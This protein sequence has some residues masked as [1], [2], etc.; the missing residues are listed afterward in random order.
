VFFYAAQTTES[1]LEMRLP[2][3]HPERQHYGLFGFMI[4]QGL[5]AGVPMTYR[6]LAQ[7]VLNQYGAMNQARHV[8]PLFSGTNLDA[9]VFGQ[10]TLPLQQ[11]KIDKGG[12]ATISAGALSRLDDGALFAIVASPLDDVK[13]ALGYAEARGV[14]LAAS[15]LVPVAQGGKPAIALGDVPAGAYARLVRLTAQYELRVAVDL[16]ECKGECPARRVIDPLRAAGADAVEGLRVKWVDAGQTADVALKVRADRVLLV[17]PSLQGLHCDT[18]T[19][20]ADRARCEGELAAGALVLAWTPAQPADALAA[21]LSQALHGIGRAT[22]LMRIAARLTTG[23]AGS[24]LVTRVTHTPASAR[25]AG[26][27]RATATPFSGEDVLSLHDGDRVDLALRNEGRVP[28]DVTVLYIDADYGVSVLF[29]QSG[30]SN[31]LE[32]GAS[33]PVLID[34]NDTTTGVERLVV[35]AVDA[36]PH[37]ERADFSFL[38][39]PPVAAMQAQR[40]RGVGAA[41]DDDSLDAFRDAGFAE[42]KTRD[43]MTPPRLP[44]ARTSM[45]VFNWNVE[46]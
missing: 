20:A 24:K 28:V 34:I 22:N 25:R 5:D 17:P 30:A 29:P 43:A 27:Q 44:S 6:Q 35:I 1:A 23:G 42:F 38:A 45:Q 15:T 2:E 10:E 12:S 40:A 41:A 11:W 18:R 32:P 33:E 36:L 26:A 4:A 9:A 16:S 37:S 31:R 3:G 7:Y 19:Q 39:Q 8:T 14:G 13:S 46:R 21:Q